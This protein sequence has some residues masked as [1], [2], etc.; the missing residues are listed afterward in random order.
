ME[1][2]KIAF[3]FR[4]R[5]SFKST[6]QKARVIKANSYR[7]ALGLILMKYPGKVIS[8]K[9]AR[10]MDLISSQVEAATL[11]RQQKKTFYIFKDKEGECEVSKD[12]PKNLDDLLAVYILGEESKSELEKLISEP[13]K[14]KLDVKQVKEKTM[15]TKTK[16]TPAKKTAK[17]AVSKKTAPATKEKIVGDKIARGNNMSLTAAEWKKVDAILAKEKISFSA[18]SRG[19]VQ[20]K[21]K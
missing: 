20:A 13:P 11:S 1:E 10:N 3:P 18:W 17:K 21:I 7:N 5:A 12:L 16:K 2:K 9:H 19:L 14:V 6:S 8:L 15:S 4:V